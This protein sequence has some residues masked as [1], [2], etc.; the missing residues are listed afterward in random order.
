MEVKGWIYFSRLK[1]RIQIQLLSAYDFKNT[2]K[3]TILMLSYVTKQLFILVFL[4]LL[5]RQKK[6]L[7]YRVKETRIALFLNMRDDDEVM[8]V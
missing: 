3:K 8:I 1:Q 4:P 2:E 6:F 7:S 5:P